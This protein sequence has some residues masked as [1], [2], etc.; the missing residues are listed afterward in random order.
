MK[1]FET[2]TLPPDSEFALAVKREP[3]KVLQM[4][5][6][7]TCVTQHGTVQGEAGD[8]LAVDSDGWPYPIS[9][10]VFEPT[11]RILADTP[12]HSPHPKRRKDQVHS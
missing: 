1:F 12:P 5:E 4:K 2:Q 9:Q 3:T 8:Y 7:F 6:P 11:Y 10:N